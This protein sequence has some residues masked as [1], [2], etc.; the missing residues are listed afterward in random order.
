MG[1]LWI[2]IAALLSLIGSHLVLYYQRKVI[3]FN[4]HNSDGKEGDPE[5]QMKDDGHIEGVAAL[6]ALS[7]ISICNP[8]F[9]I[10]PS[11]LMIAFIVIGFFINVVSFTYNSESETHFSL[12][13]L[14][15]G[16]TDAPLPDTNKTGPRF[17]AVIYFLMSLVIPVL[18]I[19]TFVI[20]YLKPM[21]RE[22][23]KIALY[24]AEVSFAWSTTGP[25]VFSLFTSVHQVPR[26]ANSLIGGLCDGCLLV[27]SEL[28]AEVTVYL[29]GTMG[30][31]IAAY[32]LLHKAHTALYYPPPKI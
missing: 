1:I 27:E 32:Y 26:F 18:N 21:K 14:G 6:T 4:G 25:L 13:S 5:E 17:M 20:L 22:A 2:F 15:M 16:I 7:G 11:I 23:Q 29:F 12:Y 24:I 8:I 9:Y 28:K 31:G 10:I 3:Y 30:H 19:I